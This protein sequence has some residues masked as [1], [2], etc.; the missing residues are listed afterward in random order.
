MRG[1]STAQKVA[2]TTPAQRLVTTHSNFIVV[3]VLPFI[4]FT[5]QCAPIHYIMKIPYNAGVSAVLLPQLWGWCECVY[6]CRTLH[7]HSRKRRGTWA[8]LGSECCVYTLFSS[9]HQHTSL[10]STGRSCSLLV[11]SLK[12]AGSLP[13]C[14][15]HTHLVATATEALLSRPWSEQKGL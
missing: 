10:C 9:P 3:L 6:V 8:T 5:Q 2:H 1:T 4:L 14:H 13:S 15:E 7:V 12:P 11:Q